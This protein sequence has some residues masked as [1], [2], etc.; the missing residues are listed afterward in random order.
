[1]ASSSFTFVPPNITPLASK[2]DGPNYTNWTTQFLLALR[3]HDL[4]GIVDGSERC[5]PQFIHDAEGKP[6][7]SISPEYSIWQKKDQ[8]ILAWINATLSNKVLSTVY[9]LDTSRQVWTHLATRFAPNS[10][11]HISHLKRQ[12]Q[13]MQQGAKECYDY[14][15]AAKSLADQLAAA[16]KPVDDEDLISYIVGDLNSSYQNFITTFSF[17]TREQSISF[18][19][20]QAKLLNFDHM[21]D[22]HQQS[23]PPA[24]NQIAFFAQKP[25]TPHYSKKTKFSPQ[26]RGLPRQH[27][28]RKQFSNSASAVTPSKHMLGKPSSSH[29]SLFSANRPPCQICGKTNH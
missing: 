11:S 19:D 15:L 23:I 16:G 18:A 28:P 17:V 2:L 12:L 27:M 10:K 1:M 9:G 29:S 14:L 20:F 13:T 4:L 6:T 25:R 8:F 3:T 24:T 22:I 5:P 26:Y 7:S 21:L